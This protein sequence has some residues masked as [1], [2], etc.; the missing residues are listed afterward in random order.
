MSD[1]HKTNE[2]IPVEALRAVSEA[3]GREISSKRKEFL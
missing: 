3:D 2:F 1:K